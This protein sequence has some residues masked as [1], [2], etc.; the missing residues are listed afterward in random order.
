MPMG[1]LFTTCC[2]KK[3]TMRMPRISCATSITRLCL[4]P[5]AAGDWLR[6]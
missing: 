5:G 4:S 6:V 1:Y 3:V 2:A